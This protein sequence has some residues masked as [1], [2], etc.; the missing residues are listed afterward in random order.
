M[1]SND[2]KAIITECCNDVIFTFNGKSSG[3]TSEVKNS[4]PTFQS[5]HGDKTKEY[6]NIDYVMSDNFFSGKSLNELIGKID[7]EF[8]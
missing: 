3:V 6:S 5:W 2:I 8:A 4:I 7:F 1:N